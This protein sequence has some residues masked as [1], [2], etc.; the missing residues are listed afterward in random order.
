MADDWAMP[1][2]QTLI[3]SGDAWL[4]EG[5]VGRAAMAAIEDG[6]CVLPAEAHRDYWGNRVPARGELRPDT[7]GTLGYANRLRAER[8]EP[9]LIEAPDGTVTEGGD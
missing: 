7:L 9:L 1:P 8:G 3:D 4:L 2:L 5:A 6:T